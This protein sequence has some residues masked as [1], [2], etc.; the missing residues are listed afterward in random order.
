[1]L[2]TT[3][4]EAPM[5]ADVARE[6]G[7]EVSDPLGPESPGAGTLE[8]QPI[9]SYP[10]IGEDPAAPQPGQRMVAPALVMVTFVVL[11]PAACFM[12]GV[13]HIILTG[14][15]WRS[16]FTPDLSIIALELGAGFL[17]LGLYW[18]LA[19][20]I[21]GALY[22]SRP[23]SGARPYLSDRQRALL[24]SVLVALLF[25]SPAI[26]Y[27]ITTALYTGLNL[28]GTVVDGGTNIPAMSAF[29]MVESFMFGLYWYVAVRLFA[30]ARS[31]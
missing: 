11:A 30:Y 7:S 9:S 13:F 27:G 22:R 16:A 19:C 21:I 31:G 29:T 12:A 8:L 15:L 17:A 4:T 6:T 3:E 24:A 18:A 25:A 10:L 2:E 26:A 28:W 20:G 23:T 14:A 5:S 1:M